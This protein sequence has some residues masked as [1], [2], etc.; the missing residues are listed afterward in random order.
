MRNLESKR[1][2]MGTPHK[3]RH[4]PFM[5]ENGLSGAIMGTRP[6]GWKLLGTN[7]GRWS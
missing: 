7:P 5:L 6:R 2:A 4:D 3:R 1:E